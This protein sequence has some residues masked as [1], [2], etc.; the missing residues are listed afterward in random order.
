VL[1]LA[2]SITRIGRAIKLIV[3]RI[4]RT[5]A[6]PFKADIVPTTGVTIVTNFAFAASYNCAATGNT[7]QA[8]S[9]L[10]AAPLATIIPAQ[11]AI[12]RWH[13]LFIGDFDINGN[14]LSNIGNCEFGS[15]RSTSAASNQ[16]CRRKRDQKRSIGKTPCP[17]Q[18]HNS[19][20]H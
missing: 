1:T 19:A 17:W 11:N 16:M 4:G 8:N 12:A 15:S 20:Q 9:A 13:T 3:T 7:S 14:H 2:I 18:A 6:H 10:T 5:S